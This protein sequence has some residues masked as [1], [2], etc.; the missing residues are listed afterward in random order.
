MTQELNSFPST[1]DRLYVLDGGL[2]IAPDRSVY[3]PGYGIGE[4]VTLSCNAYLISRQGAWIL[5]DTGIADALQ[6]QAGGAII[7]HGIRGIVVRTIR[8]QLA[9]IGLTPTDVGTVFLSHAHFDHV[10]NAALFPHAIWW[11]QRR[12]HEAMFGPHYAQYGY[13]PPLYDALRRARVEF[14]EGDH[15]VFGD[16]SMRVIATPGH[17]PGH[18][19]LLVRLAKFGPILLSADVAHDSYN[20][21]RRCVP[22]FNSDAAQSRRSM[23]RIAALVGNTGAKL[24][25][26]HDV[27]QSAT[28]AHA[29]AFFD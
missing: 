20:M 22:A 27:V 23:D 7:A 10:G 25:L 26:N 6:S 24:W 17:T 21:V 14:M 1:I 19:S 9:D 13:S 15:D 4:Q 18:C 2:A 5:W 12:E 16:G 8:D 28:I 3:S 11:V 29:P